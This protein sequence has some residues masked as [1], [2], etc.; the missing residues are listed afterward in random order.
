MLGLRLQ[1]AIDELKKEGYSNIA[2]CFTERSKSLY[3]CDLTCDKLALWVGN[4]FAGL[5]DMAITAADIELFIPMRGMIQV[6]SSR[7][8]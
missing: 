4:E 7:R 5:S 8:S 2:T 3:Q 1:E 6:F